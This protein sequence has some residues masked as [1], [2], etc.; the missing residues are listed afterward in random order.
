M[1][2]LEIKCQLSNYT[3][4]N[5]TKYFQLKLQYFTFQFLSKIGNTKQNK[6]NFFHVLQIIYFI[7]RNTQ[8]LLVT[9][10]R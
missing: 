2:N 5:I 6:K 10:I 4:L 7:G 9:I 3:I 8:F 1:S